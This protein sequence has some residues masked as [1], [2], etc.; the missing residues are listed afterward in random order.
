MNGI[1]REKQSRREE[2]VHAKTICRLAQRVFLTSLHR[3]HPVDIKIR[4]ENTPS[5]DRPSH[6]LQEARR[7]TG[8]LSSTGGARD[9]AWF[10]SQIPGHDPWPPLILTPYQVQGVDDFN[11]MLPEH[12]PTDLRFRRPPEV[13]H[14][15]FRCCFLVRSSNLSWATTRI[16]V[17]IYVNP[18]ARNN[19]IVDYCHRSWMLW[20]SSTSH[21]ILARASCPLQLCGRSPFRPS[22]HRVTSWTVRDWDYW[23]VSRAASYA[24]LE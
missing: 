20:F 9:V 17:T 18:S 23:I 2:E 13:E 21:T 11:N 7:S 14:V 5:M 12:I 3:T 19:F 8:R 1:R 6:S 24:N 10:S 16:G 15:T 22:A 4:H